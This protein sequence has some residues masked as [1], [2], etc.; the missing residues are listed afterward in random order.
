MLYMKLRNI[1]CHYGNYH[2]AENSLTTIKINRLKGDIGL[3]VD[4]YTCTH[5]H[6]EKHTKLQKLFLHKLR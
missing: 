5:T 3:H 1:Y 6:K 4:I 2:L